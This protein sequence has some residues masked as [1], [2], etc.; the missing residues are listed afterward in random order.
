MSGAVGWKGRT[1][2]VRYTLSLSFFPSM[3]SHHLHK[4]PRRAVQGLA[5]KQHRT[6]S[7]CC[8]E[9]LVTWHDDRGEEPAVTCRPSGPMTRL[10]TVE[11]FLLVIPYIHFYSSRLYTITMRLPGRPQN[12]WDDVRNHPCILSSF[13]C[14]RLWFQ[15]D[16]LWCRQILL[17]FLICYD[18]WI[19]NGRRTA[20]SELHVLLK[21]L[22]VVSYRLSPWRSMRRPQGDDRIRRRNVHSL[23][24]FMLHLLCRRLERLMVDRYIQSIHSSFSLHFCSQTLKWRW[25]SVDGYWLYTVAIRFSFPM[26]QDGK[27][28]NRC[29]GACETRRKVGHLNDTVEIMVECCP[30]PSFTVGQLFTTFSTCHVHPRAARFRSFFGPSAASSCVDET[31]IIKDK[32]TRTCP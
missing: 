14:M 23:L 21:P 31:Y 30:S 11:I 5:W 3:S 19:Y 10:H 2:T 9:V 4:T 18:K 24:S 13:P 32:R 29:W 15:A 7:S 1:L 8:L 22:N 17:L 12:D 26:L 16:S 6:L 25:R 28:E 20:L 27:V